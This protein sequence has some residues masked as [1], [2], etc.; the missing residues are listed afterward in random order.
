ML[1]FQ[2]RLD[3]STVPAFLSEFPN[4]RLRKLHI[5]EVV[6]DTQAEKLWQSGRVAASRY[7]R[8]Q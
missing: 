3:P 8:M 7:T 5:N 1:H 6:K 4:V 2:S